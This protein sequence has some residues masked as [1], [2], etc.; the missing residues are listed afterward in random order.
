MADEL[1]DDVRIWQLIRET[2]TKDL[3]QYVRQEALKLLSRRDEP[4]AW[5]LIR[6]A[7]M[8]AAGAPLRSHACG[9][10]P[11][12]ANCNKLHPKMVR[13]NLDER[14]S[15]WYDPK[16]P[17]TSGRVAYVAQNLDLSMDEVHRQYE[18]TADRLQ[19][20]LNLEWRRSS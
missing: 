8:K 3:D 13:R 17:V 6:E 19:I 11:S 5:E 1:K 4:T 10:L 7:A 2:A 18:A 20:A 9:L 14:W 12:A 15:G 16:E